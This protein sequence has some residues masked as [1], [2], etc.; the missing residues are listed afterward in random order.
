MQI[1]E[2]DLIPAQLL[3]FY[4]E[5]LLDLNDQFGLAVDGIGVGDNLRAGAFIILVG[6]ARFLA[7]S[8][9]HDNL[10]AFVGEF[11][12]RRWDDADAVFVVLDFFWH[13]D[14]HESFS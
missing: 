10:V 14:E 12:H 3:A 6:Q 8:G 13:A 5:R 7:R 9:L 4:R 11:A 1:G 2:Q